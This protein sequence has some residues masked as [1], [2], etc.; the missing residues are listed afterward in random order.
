M[1]RKIL[2]LCE[3]IPFDSGF[4]RIIKFLI[5]DYPQQQKIEQSMKHKDPQVYL[6]VGFQPLEGDQ[7]EPGGWHVTVQKGR[8]RGFDFGIRGNWKMLPIS[9]SSY[10]YCEIFTQ[11][12]KRLNSFLYKSLN[13]N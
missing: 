10:Y 8:A 11:F 2:H 12:H 3:V 9:E 7:L 4:V 1:I 5:I 13:C 6:A